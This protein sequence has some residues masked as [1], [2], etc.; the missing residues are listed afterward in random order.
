MISLVSVTNSKLVIVGSK[1]G[2]IIDTL[3]L[4]VSLSEGRMNLFPRARKNSHQT[5]ES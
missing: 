1:K 4:R 5:S 3:I 2:V